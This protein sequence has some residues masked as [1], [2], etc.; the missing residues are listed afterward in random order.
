VR[1]KGATDEG[2][3]ANEEPDSRINGLKNPDDVDPQDR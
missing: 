3:R 1:A 2:K